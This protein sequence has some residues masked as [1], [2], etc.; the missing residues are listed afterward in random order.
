MPSTPKLRPRPGS[1]VA[2]VPGGDTVLN[3]EVIK[4]LTRAFV[5]VPGWRIAH[6]Q[7]ATEP[8]AAWLAQLEASGDNLILPLPDPQ[9]QTSWSQAALD[10]A[11]TVFVV[12][13]RGGDTPEVSQLERQVYDQTLAENLHLVLTRDHSD[14]STL[15]TLDYLQDRNVFLHHQIALDAPADFARLGRFMRG[16]AVGLVLCGGGSFGTAHLGA[17][18]AMREAGHAVDFYG[19]TSI[20]AAM[21]AALATGLDPDRSMELCDELFVERRVMSKYTIPKHG[22]VNHRHLDG[23]LQDHYGLLQVEDTLVNLFAVA[24]S[25]TTNDT[26][27]MRRGPVWRAVRAS[28]SIPGVFPPVTL[29]DGEVLI[30]GGLI[31]NVPLGVM[32]DLKSGPNLVLNFQEGQP[33]RTTAAYDTLPTPMQ[34]AARLFRKPK[35]GAPR[36]PALFQVLARSMVVNARKLLSETDIGDDALMNMPTLR[37]MSFLDW[38][39]G[40]RLF[41]AAYVA[42]AQAL[43]DAGPLPDGASDSERFAHLRAAATLMDGARV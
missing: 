3:P 11:D 32:R 39:P 14:D 12:L 21:A 30:D 24:T 27:L 33:W 31:D 34:T 22:L 40:K 38:K 9:A 4:G 29:E 5:Q 8:P 6:P 26:H 18:K 35:R 16:S 41:E 10:M 7:E 36:H 42:T 20:G 28:T 13:P 23:A 17:V 15:G 19:G 25:L 2:V 37:G 1:V 43:T